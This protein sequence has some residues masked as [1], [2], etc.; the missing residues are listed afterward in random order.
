[1]ATN[2]RLKVVR[3]LKGLTQLKLAEKVG[4]KE[5]DISRFEIGR[6]SP[7]GAVLQRIAAVLQKPTF[8]LFE[9]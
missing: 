7:T 9:S 5:I 3:V 4:V 8:E 1:M 2:T 6:I